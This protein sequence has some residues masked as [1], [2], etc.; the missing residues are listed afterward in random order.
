MVTVQVV[1]DCADPGGLARFWAEVL[2]YRFEPPPPGF[3]SWEEWAE[4]EGIPPERWNDSA[5]LVG[6]G[7]RIFFQRV[8]TPKPEKNRLHLDVK[9]HRRG[10]P[11]E[12]RRAEVDAF[13]DRLVGL[14]GA[15]VA[16]HE[17][18]GLYWVVMRDPEGNEFCVS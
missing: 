17:E 4:A 1:I 8:P 10:D 6:D 13:A 3:A 15:R 7:P 12:R 11:I 5:V 9:R 14:G 18:D 16:G 2:G